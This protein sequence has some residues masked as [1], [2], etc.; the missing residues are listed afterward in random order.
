LIVSLSSLLVLVVTGVATSNYVLAR[1]TIFLSLGLELAGAVSLRRD[2]R[3]FALIIILASAIVFILNL[4]AQRPEVLSGSP[5]FGGASLAYFNSYQ[6]T[7]HIVAL[8]PHS[9]YFSGY[10]FLYLLS[11]VP[12]Y[13][14]PYLAYLVAMYGLAIVIAVY[15]LRIA[16]D[17]EEVFSS[18]LYGC[19]L[20]CFT[21]F[22]LYEGVLN[23]INDKFVSLAIFFFLIGT[24][25]RTNHRMTSPVLL[26]ILVF[27]VVVGSLPFSL[28]L[29][30]LGFV[31][32]A[33]SKARR[34]EY[35]VMLVIPLLWFAYQGAT[36]GNEYLKFM[37]AIW[38]GLI[39]SNSFPSPQLYSGFGFPSFDTIISRAGAYAV[40]LYLLSILVLSL[41]SAR[42]KRVSVPGIGLLLAFILLGAGAVGAQLAVTSSGLK[43]SADVNVILLAYSSLVGFAALITFAASSS[44]SRTKYSKFF[45]VIVV[46]IVAMA[47]IWPIYL[48]PLSQRDPSTTVEQYMTRFQ[49]PQLTTRTAYV[50][51]YAGVTRAV[52]SDYVTNVM[53]AVMLATT[54]INES[55]YW[56]AFV[57]HRVPGNLILYDNVSKSLPSYILPNLDVQFAA[58]VVADSDIVYTSGELVIGYVY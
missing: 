30:G 29:L 8:D 20:V 49:I 10:L 43:T 36:Y 42:K 6:Q 19:A 26:V 13:N 7:G 24:L 9:N 18:A 1:I 28:L 58:T 47:S 52:Y 22:L 16:S 55:V 44:I 17:N 46:F 21:N 56:K 54:G 32:V 5:P 23:G 2:V 39:K 27:G 48:Y 51:S 15:W 3:H 25:I 37:G 34:T 11:L 53:S 12:A 38:D 33:K 40:A 31:G 50:L 35:L 4:L 41:L 57:V 14:P 45:V